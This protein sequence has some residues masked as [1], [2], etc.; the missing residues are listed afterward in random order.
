MSSSAA[1]R[2]RK[3]IEWKIE[4][5]NDPPDILFLA[6]RSGGGIGHLASPPLPPDDNGNRAL[7]ALLSGLFERAAALGQ[8]APKC[9]R[10]H[11]RDLLA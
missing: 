4:F 2:S 1:L 8:P 3:L 11:G 6:V 9:L 5:V 10:V 7:S